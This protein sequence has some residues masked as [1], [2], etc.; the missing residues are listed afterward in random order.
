MDKIESRITEL[1]GLKKQMEETSSIKRLELA[2]KEAE[3][4]E[5]KNIINQNIFENT[6]EY[7]ELKE[8]KITQRWLDI[9]SK[10]EEIEIEIEGE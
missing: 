3:C 7:K 4:N 5:I 9:Y 1:E 8:L 10:E 6:E 2:N